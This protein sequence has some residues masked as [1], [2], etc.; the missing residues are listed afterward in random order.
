MTNKKIKSGVV[1]S[2]VFCILCGGSLTPNER[3]NPEPICDGCYELA[4]VED[5][6]S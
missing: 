6:S 1:T 4:E 2:P 5:T 3:N